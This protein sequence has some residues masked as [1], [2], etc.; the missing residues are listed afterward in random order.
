MEILLQDSRVELLQ[1]HELPFVMIGRC[2][3]NE[4]LSYVD[5]DIE[6]GVAD[7]FRHL[8]DLGHRQIG[9]VTLVE[10]RQEK[11][12]S[13]TH[14]AVKGYESACQEYGLPFIWRVVDVTADNAKSV[15][16]DMLDEFPALTAIVTPQ[17]AGVIGVLKATQ[18]RGIRIPQDI[19]VVGLLESTVGELITPPLTSLDFPAHSLGVEAAKM[20]INRLEGTV[21]V[22]QQLLLQPQLIV[23]DSTGPARST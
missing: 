16:L 6:K 18:E 3:N 10:T 7:A 22:P 20:M 12:Y 23:R 17:Q 11:S 9:F 5:V 2:E 21:D 15:V 8:Y 1:Q 13:F 19:S 4:G 14:W